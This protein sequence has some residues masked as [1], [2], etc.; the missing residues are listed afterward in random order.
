MQNKPKTNT[1]HLNESKDLENENTLYYNV[2]HVVVRWDPRKAASN[3]K[4]HGVSFEEASTVL[5][6]RNTIEIEDTRHSEQR[7]IIIGFS[8]RTRLLTVVY[9]YRHEDE[10]RIISARKATKNEAKIYEERI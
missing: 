9:V 2:S 1:D 10:I 3:I 5:F 6:A 7:F 4:K 8:I